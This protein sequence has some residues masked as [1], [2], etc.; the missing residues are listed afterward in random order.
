MKTL[1]YQKIVDTVADLCM[2]ANMH[3]NN[4]VLTAFQTSYDNEESEVGKEVLEKLIENAKIASEE[5]VAMCQDTGVAVCFVEVGQDLVI[6]GGELEKAIEEG[7][8]KGYQEGYLRK[9]MCH[10]FTR[11]NTGD[12]T[13]PVI[14]TR[15]VPGDNLKITVA[16]KGG[17]SENMS[18]LKMLTP[19]QGKKGVVDFVVK[20]VEEAGPNPCPPIVVGVGIG[21][22]FERCALLAK[23]SLLRP[24]DKEN[25]DPELREMEKEILQKINNLG[26]GPQGFGGRTTALA[27]HI[28]M[29]PCHIA[30]LPVAVNINCHAAR[31]AEAVL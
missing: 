5:E 14:H 25:S 21:G 12:N 26:I 28:E 20:T 19:A 10:P 9:S 17:G 22:N 24:L 29:E 8:R 13:P 30:S 16:P 18:A 27:V 4:D 23:K 31:H 1:E 7:I 11:K 6:T 15:V 2:K 3:L